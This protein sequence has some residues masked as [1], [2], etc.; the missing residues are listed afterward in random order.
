MADGMLMLMLKRDCVLGSRGIA[1][2]VRQNT[3]TAD[4]TIAVPAMT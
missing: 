3:A 2:M 1:S 4:L